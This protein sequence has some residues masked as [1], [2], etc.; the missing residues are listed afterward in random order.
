MS[1][2]MP[3]GI[4]NKIGRGGVIDIES[5]REFR[6][7]SPLLNW[8]K[9]LRTELIS[10]IYEKPIYPKNLYLQRA[11]MKHA[12]YEKQVTRRQIALMQKRGIYSLS[13]R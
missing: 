3:Y 5:L 7:R 8:M 13:G 9:D 4:L 11:P 1:S 6:S 2:I 10:L 12:E